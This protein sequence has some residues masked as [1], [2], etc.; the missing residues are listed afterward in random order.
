MLVRYTDKLIP[1]LSFPLVTFLFFTAG[2]VLRLLFGPKYNGT[3]PL[4]RILVF[5]FI[6]ISI[7][8]LFAQSLIATAHEKEYLISIAI[9]ALSNVGLNFIFIPVYGARGAAATTIL[10]EFLGSIYCLWIFKKKVVD[11]P[12]LPHLWRPLL[13]CGVLAVYF[14]N[15][16]NILPVIPR[17]LI[18]I[19]IYAGAMHLL[20]FVT[21]GDL[22]NLRSIHPFLARIIPVPTPHEG[23]S[24]R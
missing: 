2:P 22:A 12:L 11:E 19:P 24:P 23:G 14:L 21:P 1:A 4:F 20:G 13:G 3:I 9:A 6:I 15:T 7:N 17:V 18:G 5:A 16:A 8:T 10:A